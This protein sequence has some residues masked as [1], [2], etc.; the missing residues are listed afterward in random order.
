MERSG[1]MLHNLF[2][3]ATDAIA[4]ID[5]HTGRFLDCNTKALENLGYG[6][7]EFLEITVAD[8]HDDLSP[9]DIQKLFKKQILGR[10][11]RIET[12]HKRKN[13]GYMP[14]EITSTLIRVGDRE[15]LQAFIR[16]ITQRKKAEREKEALIEKL[17]KALEEIHTLQGILPICT[18]CKS[19]RDDKGYWEQ[20]DTYLKDRTGARISHGLCPDCARKH[21]PEFY[22][23]QDPE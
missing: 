3:F 11:M 14:V 2:E 17:E 5:P 16:D 9:S 19:V 6:R 23:P 22:P 12:V 18:F 4:I 7:E 1:E 21:Y 8:L 13:G 15:V 10:S 20:V